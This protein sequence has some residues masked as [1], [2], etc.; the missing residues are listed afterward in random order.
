MIDLLEAEIIVWKV[1]RYIFKGERMRT[2]N[3]IKNVRCKLLL[4]NLFITMKKPNSTVSLIYNRTK[5]YI[6]HVN[7]LLL[8]LQLKILQQENISA[9]N[10]ITTYY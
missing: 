10:K 7:I 8:I 6:I 4:A 1:H 5:I 2:E 3:Q 9:T